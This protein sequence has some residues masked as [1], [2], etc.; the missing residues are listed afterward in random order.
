MTLLHIYFIKTSLFEST[1]ADLCEHNTFR[2]LLKPTTARIEVYNADTGN[3][4]Q[5]CEIVYT[6][7]R[8][9]MKD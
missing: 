1:T 2:F 6:K 8:H 5:G 4:S 7:T 9:R 3:Q